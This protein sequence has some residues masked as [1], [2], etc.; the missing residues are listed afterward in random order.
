MPRVDNESFYRS[1]LDAH[2][3]TARGV[4]WN[5]TESQEVRFQ[6][7]RSLL[8]ADLS[9]LTL[10]DAGCGFGDLYCYLERE[11]ARPGRY[12]GLDVMLPMVETA[13]A[14]TGC[15]ILIRDVI[16]G[17]LPEA[18]Y[19]LCSGAMNTLTRDESEQFIRSCYAASACGFVFNLL[20]GWNTSS[21]YNLYQP[22][23]IK[24]LA[25]ELDAA[26]LIEEGYLAGDFTVSLLK[27]L[28]T[29]DT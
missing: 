12:I 3:E 21:I 8:P 17:P 11:G 29:P 10:V 27:P 15:E 14:R 20:K 28:S 7:L 13:R 4:H 18:D 2:G 1:A 19:Y 6:V 26:C 16:N 5:S 24:R 25:R 23:E 22:R 9:G